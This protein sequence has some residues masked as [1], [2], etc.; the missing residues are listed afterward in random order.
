MVSGERACLRC[1]VRRVGLWMGPLLLVLVAGLAGW[2]TPATTLADG[3]SMARGDACDGLST[4]ACC[5]QSLDT[6]I[7]KA[8][9]DQ[10]ERRTRLVTELACKAKKKALSKHVCRQILV[11][12]GVAAAEA[13]AECRSKGLAARCGKDKA[14]RTCRAQLSAMGYRDQV[15]GAC[16]AATWH[17]EAEEPFRVR[18]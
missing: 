16:L 7:F 18:M 1:A 9:G 8:S 2:G 11:S 3:V 13:K 10:P 6:Y 5:A 12:R 17:P 14:C 4:E 15:A